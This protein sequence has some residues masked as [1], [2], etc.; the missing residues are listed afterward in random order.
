MKLFFTILIIIFGN[1]AQSKSDDQS[2]K[3]YEGTYY[4][5]FE[6]SYF[7]LDNGKEKWWLIDQSWNLNRRLQ[8][9]ENR[10]VK[11]KFR[12]TLS[13]PG[14]FGHMGMYTRQVLVKEL[15]SFELE[16]SQ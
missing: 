1:V 8:T 10:K 11:I 14:K 2:F 3:T 7:I 9:T 6:Q 12:G 4:H 16:P 15:I 13:K 5:G